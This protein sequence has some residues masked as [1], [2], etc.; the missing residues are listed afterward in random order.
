MTFMPIFFL[1]F[2]LIF[3]KN[4]EIKSKLY[5]LLFILNWQSEDYTFQSLP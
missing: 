3:L 5:Y 2:V 1:Y 4:N